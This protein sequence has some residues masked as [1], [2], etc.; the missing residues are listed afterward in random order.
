MRGFEYTFIECFQSHTNI[1]VKKTD[2]MISFF[3]YMG[4]AA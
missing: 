1:C 4:L 3:F 2:S